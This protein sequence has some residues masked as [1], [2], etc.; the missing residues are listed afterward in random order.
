MQAQDGKIWIAWT[1]GDDL[2]YKVLFEN[3]TE[4]VPDTQLTSDETS[5]HPSIMQAEDGKI[6]IAWDSDRLEISE[7]LGIYCK[8]FYNGSSSEERT[9]FNDADDMWPSIM[10]DI[11]GT[12]WIAWTSTRASNFDIYYKTDS[13]PQHDHDMAI[14]SVTHDPN[15]T[16]AYQ[17]L[18]ISIEVLLQNQ[19]KNWENFV[20]GCYANSTP[21]GNQTTHLPAGQLTS[22]PVGFTWN[23]SDVNPGTYTI[24]ANV[25]IT[26]QNDTDPADNTFIDG[27]V[28]VKIPGDVN[29]EGVVDA[30]DFFDLSEAYGSGI[31][32]PSWNPD[33]DFNRDNKVDTSDLFDLNEN[34]GKTI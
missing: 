7:G 30:F 21:I 19:G 9:T 11:N 14:F 26:G 1:R 3:K 25:T 20:V 27:Q 31:G 23:T 17:G 4:A 33:C 18:S 34:Y 24:I 28:L 10:Q 6:W 32:D 15:V 22:P 5:S 2:F 16:V 29:G 12:I 8:T 13:P